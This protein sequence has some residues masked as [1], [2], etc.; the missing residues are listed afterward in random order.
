MR[1]CLCAGMVGAASVLLLGLSGWFLTAAA[2]AGLAGSATA[3]AFNYMLP[4]AGIRLLAIARTGSRYGERLASHAAALRTTSAVREKLFGA[5]ARLPVRRALSLGTG[6]A[7]THLVDNVATVEGALVRRTALWALFASLGAGGSLLLLAGSAPLCALAVCLATMLAIGE[8]IA[9][10]LTRLGG[11]T[12]RAAAALKEELGTLAQSA[13]ELRCYRLDGWAAE[14]VGLR[15]RP[16][17]EAQR[18]TTAT[19]GMLDALV[20][21]TGAVAGVSCFVLAAAAGAPIA[22]LAAL[23]AIMA[24]DGAAAW[25][26][27]RAASG[28]VA[29]ASSHLDEVFIG[30]TPADED[31]ACP[32]DIDMTT[33]FAVDLHERV[34]IV[35]PSGCGKT[36]IVEGLIALRSLPQGRV[37]IE[38]LDVSLHS[39]AWL[40]SQFAWCP[41]DALCLAGTVR[42]NLMP[43]GTPGLDAALWEVL[44]DAMLADRVR[45]LGGLDVWIGENGDRLS[46]GE[47]R[48]LA[49]ARAYLRPAPCLLL[50]EPTEGLDRDTEQDVLS[51][52]ERRLVRTGQGLILVSHRSA[53]LRL[54][55][56]QVLLR[57]VPVARTAIAA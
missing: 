53:P 45:Q 48:R 34:A 36:S 15:D 57:A 21:F 18:A 43:V 23:C 46:G 24:V 40:R 35:G 54:C 44:E 56:R 33:S 28:A 9:G 47:R 49:L 12:Q 31:L 29:S 39:V 42:A 50:D 27:G 13:A 32:S 30:A 25:V 22:A 38:G 20:G 26:R 10:R 41:Q 5:I 16:L 37:T 52:L 19:L 2:A 14:R 8:V 6:N 3:Q 55:D 1:A 7:S 17:G 11:E 4:A 51:A